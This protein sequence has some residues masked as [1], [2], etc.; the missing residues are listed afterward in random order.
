MRN[1]YGH[2]FL[3]KPGTRVYV[4]TDYGRDRGAEIKEE[5]GSRWKAPANFYHLR[6]GGHVAAVREH[7]DASFLASLD[8]Q[9]FFDQISRSKIFRSL[10]KLG[11]SQSEA[12]GIACDSTVDK[13]PPARKFSLPFGFVQSPLVASLVLAHSALGKR[14][15]R[16][17]RDGVT[18]TVYMDDITISADSE[19][20]V[21]SA[22][23]EIVVA[24][25]LSGFSFNPDKTQPTASAVTSFNIE[26]G[27]G[28]MSIMADRLAELAK[29]FES[30]NEA[31]Q[32]G[33]YGYVESVNVNQLDAL[34]P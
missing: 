2:H 31:Q 33:I 22:V 32:M 18:T 23:D 24:G 9:R 34:D 7:R 10:K 28:A 25:E 3:L 15:E 29:A 27:S 21:S 11:F 4:P 19:S 12:W 6:D 14:I 16:I 8:L 30:G 17:R 26:F 5:I 20:V 13:R 1:L